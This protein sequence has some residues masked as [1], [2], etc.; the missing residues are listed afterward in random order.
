MTLMST[1]KG[2]TDFEMIFINFSS[3][4]TPSLII[5]QF[6]HYCEYTKTHKGIILRPKSP[7]KWLVVFCDEINLPDEDAY[8]T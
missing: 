3:S 1:L 7:N 2:L 8:G 5:K 4:T 6:D